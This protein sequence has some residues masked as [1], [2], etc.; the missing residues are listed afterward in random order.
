METRNENMAPA[1]DNRRG[2]ARGA[3][4][5]AAIVA[6]VA[7]AS[8]LLYL[9][10]HAGRFSR[11]LSSALSSKLWVEHGLVFHAS[12]D[13]AIPVETIS[14]RQI[15]I[16]DSPRVAT[17][18]GYGRR[19]LPGRKRSHVLQSLPRRKSDE[20][21]VSML[22]APDSLDGRQ[23]VMNAMGSNSGMLMDVAD[24]DVVATFRFG[25]NDV[26]LAAPF[27]AGPG[28]FSRVVLTVSRAE[29]AIYQNGVRCATISLPGPMS[30]PNG[31]MALPASTHYLFSG[32]VDEP[33]IWNRALG[34]DEAIAISQS[35]RG[36]CFISEPL[37]TASLAVARGMDEF[38]R[39][40]LRALDRIAPRA[41]P[42]ALMRQDC[43]TL[44]LHTSG[45]DARHFVRAHEQSLWNGYRTSKAAN[46][47]A[48]SATFLGERRRV[49]V[50]LDDVYRAAP[51]PRRQCF[52]IRGD[53]PTLFGGCHTARL[54]PPEAHSVIHPFAPDVLP[55]AARYVRLYEGNTFKGIYAIEPFDAPGSAWIARGEADRKAL[56]WNGRPKPP[57]LLPRGVTFEEAMRASSSL[58]LS[59]SLF[60]WSAWELR[61]RRR[62][63]A[64]QRGECG[65]ADF[66]DAIAPVG[67]VIG[68]NPAPMFITRDLPLASAAGPTVTWESSDP[69]V[70]SPAGEVHRPDGVHHAIVTL[71]ATDS[72]TGA[73]QEYR[74][75]VMARKRTLPTLFVSINGLPSRNRRQDFICT[76]MSEDD[77]EPAVRPGL[78][79]AGGGFRNHG[80]TSYVLGVKRPMA[81][82][83]EEPVP[84]PDPD[85]PSK[86][87]LLH[88]G[89][90]DS[91]RLRNKISFDAF[92]A[93]SQGRFPTPRFDFC[94]VFVNNEWFGVWEAS[95]R[96]R[97][98]VPTN[99]LLYKVRGTNSSIWRGP[100]VSMLDCVQGGDQ[101]GPDPYSPMRDLFSFTGSASHES[102][103]SNIA[104]RVD[105]DNVANY[106]MLLAFTDNYDAVHMNQYFARLPG[107]KRFLI[108][109][110]DY[111]KAFSRRGQRTYLNHLGARLLNE[112]DGFGR[113]MESKW[114]QLRAGP[115][116][117]EAV[118]GRIDGDAA[119]LEP[120]MEEEWRLV[121]PKQD[122]GDFAS[123]VEKLKSSVRAQLD[124][125]DQLRWR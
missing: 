6:A 78:V 53:F 66:H 115:L 117:D 43:P 69:S 100:Q 1:C 120:Y 122:V 80:N 73:R 79:G 68:G 10:A 7:A 75:R 86:H 83:F 88:N 116:S 46:L 97:D 77:E 60:P 29:A 101:G 107:E 74:L 16:A 67:A 85:H 91:T 62:A 38:M 51:A 2:R 87:I 92:Q 65:F 123:E 102:F 84:W 121:A 58:A 3:I 37:L 55:V 89:F 45:A 5:A 49:E 113:L 18:C 27:A 39:R 41:G 81:L 93:A 23:R 21:S 52:V 103:A 118:F 61:K 124:F 42:P 33:A 109:P 32:V 12:L 25:T 98:L 11:N 64:L 34:E 94:E 111:D 19:I 99:A 30:M 4:R 105:I 31:R 59:D 50:G 28:R 70:I 15:F 8:G 47:Q 26:V 119:R 22:L 48:M 104:E 35:R 95:R 14:G 57:D 114:R 106:F 20:Y 110:W 44:V 13:E 24:G 54:Y 125:M 63:L 108:I 72:S 112:Y 17:P 82:K 40:A 90:I 9:G 96:V 71:T 56:Y 36:I 76:F